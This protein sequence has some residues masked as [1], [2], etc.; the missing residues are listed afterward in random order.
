[1]CFPVV[2]E[3]GLQCVSSFTQK[4]NIELISQS[5]LYSREIAFDLY[6]YAITQNTHQLYG[7]CESPFTGRAFNYTAVQRWTKGW[8]HTI[9]MGSVIWRVS[10][11]FGHWNNTI[12]D[13]QYAYWLL[14]GS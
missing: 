9:G 10:H 14:Q 1:M 11:A 6:L 4:P 3:T 2:R 8:S 13:G 7:K 5:F 12:T